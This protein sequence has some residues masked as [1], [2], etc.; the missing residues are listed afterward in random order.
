MSRK[1]TKPDYFKKSLAF[2]YGAVTAYKDYSK[3]QYYE[4]CINDLGDLSKLENYNPEYR[5]YLTM[6][7]EDIWKEAEKV[8]HA[9]CNRNV[10]LKK[11]IR[12]IIDN[13]PTTFVTLT[14][15]DVILN[16]TS[17]VT[18]RKYVTL[19]LKSHGVPYVANVDYGKLNEREHYHAIIGSQTLNYKGWHHFGAINGKKVVKKTNLNSNGDVKLAKYITKLTNHAIKETCKRNAIIYSR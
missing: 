14:F 16:T 7:R 1:Y 17:E 15:T 5:Q 19:W 18:R 8:N 4:H 11:R 12:S 13:Y 9:S 10:R 6:F 3:N 2:Q